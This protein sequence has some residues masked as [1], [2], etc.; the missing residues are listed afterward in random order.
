[1]VRLIRVMASTPSLRRPYKN[2]LEPGL[3][4]A[5]GTQPQQYYSSIRLPVTHLPASLIPLGEAYSNRDERDVRG[6]K[7]SR[8]LTGC[9]DDTV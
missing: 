5:E 2:K 1:M 8:A 3:R 6:L 4:L 9:D 7:K